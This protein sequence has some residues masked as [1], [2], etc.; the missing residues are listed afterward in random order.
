MLNL[1]ALLN[2]ALKKDIALLCRVFKSVNRHLAGGLR[3]ANA[4]EFQNIIRDGF[5]DSFRGDWF[6]PKFELAI[7]NA[8][9]MPHYSTCVAL[10]NAGL[11]SFAFDRSGSVQRFHLISPLAF[12][13]FILSDEEQV[14]KLLKNTY[15]TVVKACS[16][17]GRPLVHKIIEKIPSS[18]PTVLLAMLFLDE[19]DI[20]K[21]ITPESND[22]TT[23]EIY[24]MK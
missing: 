16:C 1:S 19:M 24:N 20:L 7:D 17:V 10:D 23:Y 18:E 13:C 14:V 22:F 21:V 3:N 9:F 8:S 12:L 15:G 6:D 11:I 2:G 5:V 4:I